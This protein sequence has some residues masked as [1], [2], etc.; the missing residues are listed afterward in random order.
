M[1]ELGK[2][3][4]N[5]KEGKGIIFVSLKVDICR[6]VISKQVHCMFHQ[7]KIFLVLKRSVTQ[8][9]QI[10]DNRSKFLSWVYILCDL[11]DHR[12]IFLSCGEGNFSNASLIRLTQ[13]NPNV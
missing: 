9:C 10:I 12:F 8:I 13:H 5:R 4:K 1:G 11:G 6:G 7:R 2:K 3:L